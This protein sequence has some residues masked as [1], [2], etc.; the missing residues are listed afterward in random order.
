[1]RLVIILSAILLYS[2]ASAQQRFSQ[3]QM[4][5]DEVVF[6][7]LDSEL[8]IIETKTIEF[9][10]EDTSVTQIDVLLGSSQGGADFLN[11]SWIANADTTLDE[12]NNVKFTR[13]GISC[14]VGLGTW[15]NREEAYLTLRLRNS[16]GGIIEEFSTIIY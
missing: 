13:L 1:M 8:R 16:S 6:D 4:L 14:T 9:I 11:K 7:T 5:P 10:L 2:S 15:I 3:F 12:Q